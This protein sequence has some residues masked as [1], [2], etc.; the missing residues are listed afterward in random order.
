MNNRPINTRLNSAVSRVDWPPRQLAATAQP[1]VF[2]QRAQT[3]SCMPT[4]LQNARADVSRAQQFIKVRCLRCWA[5]LTDPADMRLSRCQSLCVLC[6]RCHEENKNLPAC[7]ACRFPMKPVG[8]QVLPPGVTTKDLIV[9]A[10]VQLKKALFVADWQRSIRERY[11]KH[12]EETILR[13]PRTSLPAPT[14]SLVSTAASSNVP[15]QIMTA[16]HRP[17][18]TALRTVFNQPSGPL[19]RSAVS[20]LSPA[21]RNKRSNHEPTAPRPVKVHRLAKSI[22][23]TASETKR[24]DFA[25]KQVAQEERRSSA[26]SSLVN[27]PANMRTPPR[28]K[29]P[30]R[31]VR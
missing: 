26:L 22:T 17:V 11:T 13:G 25:S 7:Q 31:Q 1:A 23:E 24:I 27:L 19:A 15:L 28:S 8:Q 9:P 21:T 12:L 16:T 3:P 6:V 4:P 30:N 2:A 10:N 18:A 14:K 5:D 29:V 20:L